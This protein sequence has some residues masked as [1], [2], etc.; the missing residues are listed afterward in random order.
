[1]ALDIY[2]Q[3]TQLLLNDPN[4]EYF[5]PE[6]LTH[7]INT[8][9]GQ[10]AGTTEAIRVYANLT[11]S[12][13]SQQY[14]FT[15]INVGS[16]PGVQEVLAINQISYAVG[17]GQKSIHSRSWPWFN[18]Y[19]I[20]QPVPTAGP[21]AVWSQFGPGANSSLYINLLDNQYVLSVD[22]SCSPIDLV[23]NTTVEAIPYP[24]TDSIPWFSAYYALSTTGDDE[25]A[26]K[27]FKQYEKFVAMAQGSDTPEV[28]P[29][30]FNS[31]QDPFMANRLGLQQR[32]GQ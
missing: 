2:L 11:V 31:S 22:A 27:M 28:L 7:Y 32:G 14:T 6:D 21:P 30:N 9:R 5:N 19:I 18:S 8:A 29:G 20:G 24:L 16:T 17:Q 13:N 25:K 23:D 26:E 10:L 3:R 4:F 15:S 1:M 12:A